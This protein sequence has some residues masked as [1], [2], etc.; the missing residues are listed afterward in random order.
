[1][2]E[3]ITHGTPPPERRYVATCNACGA[4]FRFSEDEAVRSVVADDLLRIAC[5]TCK[6]PV[7]KH[8]HDYERLRP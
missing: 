7:T 6:R 5:P 1:M 4:R 3:I 2:I 8:A